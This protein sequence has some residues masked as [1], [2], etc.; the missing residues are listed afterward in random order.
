[1]E[2]HS[3]EQHPRRTL[4]PPPR[5]VPFLLRCQ[6]LANGAAVWGSVIFGLVSILVVGLVSGMDPL[7]SLRLA[8]HR[9][10]APVLVQGSVHEP[11]GRTGRLIFGLAVAFRP[12]CP[13]LRH[14]GRP[15]C[16]RRFAAVCA[17]NARLCAPNPEMSQ[18]TAYGLKT[19]SLAAC[20]SVLRYKVEG[21]G[22]YLPEGGQAAA[23]TRSPV[24]ER[25]G[26]LAL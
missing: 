6:L 13:S 12:A 25:R 23:Y 24:Q 9:Q 7:G 21:V 20:P 16:E 1:M 5:A 4:A 8:L 17:P 15:P 10:E 14:K 22:V 18:F 26:L 11:H 2:A 3:G 19:A